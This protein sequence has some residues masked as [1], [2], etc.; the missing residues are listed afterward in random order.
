MK[1][2]WRFAG[3]FGCIG[4]A[5]SLVVAVQ[6][7]CLSRSEIRSGASQTSVQRGDSTVATRTMDTSFLVEYSQTRGYSCGLP[8]NM[9]L[10]PN[11]DAV[12]FL[13]SG[14]RDVIRD[15]YEMDT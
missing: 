6:V 14:P 12:L 4:L 1:R 10:T 9:N 11:G 3:R 15:L 7:A 5:L 8:T 13:R 2:S